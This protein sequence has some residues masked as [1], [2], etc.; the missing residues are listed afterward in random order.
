[1]ALIPPDT[2]VCAD[3]MAEVLDPADRRHRYPFTACTYCGPR[4]TLV[5]GVPY[6]RPYT[7]MAGFP[8]CPDCAREYEDPADRRF[9]AQ[10][11]A[12]PVCGPRL[13]FRAEGSAEPDVDGG[14]R[15]GRRAAR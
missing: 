10:P 4:F 1:M 8:L 13:S 9:H 5:R 14:R 3:C 7:T 2:A 12:C 15:A 11:T 6:D